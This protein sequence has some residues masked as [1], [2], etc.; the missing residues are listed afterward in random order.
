MGATEILVSQSYYN[1]GSQKDH[2]IC[3]NKL[4]CYSLYQKVGRPDLE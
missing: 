2:V 3:M 1:Q 4:N